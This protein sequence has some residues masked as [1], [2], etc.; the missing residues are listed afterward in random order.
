MKPISKTAFYCCGVRMQDAKHNNPICGD[1]YAEAFMN[2]DGLKIFEA[3]KDET[4]PN[5]SNATRHRIIDDFLRQELLANPNLHIVI[6]GAGFDSR[7]YRIQG[8]TWIE[9]DEPQVIAY[10]NERLPA[11]NCENE[12]HRIS[13]DFSSESLEEK[14][15]PFLN[16]NSVVVVIEGVLMYLE[17]EAIDQSLQI[18][19]RLFP[20]HKLICD[21]MSRNFFEKFSKSFHKKI[22]D[23]GTTFKFTADHPEAVFLQNGYSQIKKISIIET[24]VELKAVRVP[25]IALKTVLRTL[26][27]GYAIYIFNLPSVLI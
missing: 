12:L 2:E 18:L 25:K 11:S 27:S 20:T 19:R 10:K 16:N 15:S 5:A 7:A 4:A 9:L 21:L 14:L 1:I 24:A 23:V 17:E 13:I 26:A 22:A 6:I 3:F 8:G